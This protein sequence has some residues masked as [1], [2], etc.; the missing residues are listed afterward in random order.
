MGLFTLLLRVVVILAVVI[1]NLT[2]EAREYVNSPNLMVSLD[3]GQKN[4]QN[5][6]MDGS[7]F[8]YSLKTY[9]EL[10]LGHTA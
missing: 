9:E 2:H 6:L 8:C 10:E 5:R 4:R 1:K 3:R 7:T